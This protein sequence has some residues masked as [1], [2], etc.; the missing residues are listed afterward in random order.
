MNNFRCK[1]YIASYHIKFALHSLCLIAVWYINRWNLL[2]LTTIFDSIIY[3]K[4]SVMI[5]LEIGFVSP[6]INE[7]SG[8]GNGSETLYLCIT[9]EVLYLAYLLYLSFI[10]VKL[11]ILDITELSYYWAD[12]LSILLYEKISSVRHYFIVFVDGKCSYS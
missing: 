2:F 1:Y 9:K 12:W 5:L 4:M 10:Y 7:K 8:L 11:S 6:K 3:D